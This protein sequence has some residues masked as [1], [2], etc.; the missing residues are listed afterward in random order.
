[1]E[2]LLELFAQ[3]EFRLLIS[4]AQSELRSCLSEAQGILYG[5]IGWAHF[6]LEEFAEAITALDKAIALNPT[7]TAGLRNRGQAEVV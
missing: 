2:K 7:Y 1:M 3:R 5:A 6:E 4:Y